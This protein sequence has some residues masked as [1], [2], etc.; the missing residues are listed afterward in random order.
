MKLHT[1]VGAEILVRSRS[2]LLRMSEEIVLTHHEWWDGTGY[3]SGLEGER[4]PL[5]GRIVAVADV[6]DTLTGRRSYKAPWPYE[7]AV[8]EIE[9]LRG[10]QLDPQLV[11]VFLTVL[12]ELL[13]DGAADT[14]VA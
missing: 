13:P 3:P 9:R 7:R 12:H 14:K 11:D 10:R 5:T 8:A 2:A 4:I 6:F 1:V